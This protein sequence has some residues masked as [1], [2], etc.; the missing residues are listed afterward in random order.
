[1][2]GQLVGGVPDNRLFS[3]TDSES[4]LVT[5]D[6]DDPE[7]TVDRLASEG[8]GVRALSTPNGVRASVHAVTMRAEIDRQL[9]ALEQE[10]A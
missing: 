7:T 10:W 4:G 6:V 8:V 9:D 2:A 1:M 3:P 5:I